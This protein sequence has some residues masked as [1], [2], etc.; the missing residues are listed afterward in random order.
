MSI[1]RGRCGTV[2]SQHTPGLKFNKLKSFS[3]GEIDQN[4][5]DKRILGGKGLQY[6][7]S[8]SIGRTKVTPLGADMNL[9]ATIWSAADRI[10]KLILRG[11][12]RMVRSHPVLN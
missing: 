3:R 12:C 6:E 8:T 10:R 1:L 5:V 9:S 11:Q 4:H 2:N 7:D